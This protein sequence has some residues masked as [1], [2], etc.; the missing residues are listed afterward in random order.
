MWTDKQKADITKAVK[1]YKEKLRPLIRSANLYH[2]LPRPDERSRD[3]IEYFDPATGKGV[4]YLFQPT[5]NDKKPIKLK[6]LDPVANY[7]LEFED[8]SNP[9]TTMSG[10]E[11]M[12][13]GIVINL[14][15]SESSELMFI[16]HIK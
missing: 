13:T 10:A 7:K 12:Q 11:L 3:G 16:T 1:T 14:E 8:G 2:I 9:S 6:G 5:T 15:G 4:V